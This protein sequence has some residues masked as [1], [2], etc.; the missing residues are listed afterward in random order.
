MKIIY[1]LPFVFLLGCVAAKAQKGYFVKASII[2][3]D[4]DTLQGYIDR[5]RDSRLSEGITFKQETGSNTEQKFKPGDLLGFILKDEHITC[6]TI[7]YQHIIAGENISE[8]RFAILLLKGYCSLYYLALKEDE[9]KI[10]F[11]Q[12]NDHIFLAKK[13]DAFTVLRQSEIMDDNTYSL[14]KDYTGELEKLFSDC[15]SINENMIMKTEFSKKSMLKIFEKYNLCI[16]PGVPVQSYVNTGKVKIKLGI[17]ASYTFFSYRNA[18]NSSGISGGF[19]ITVTNPD[20][21]ER[22]SFSAGFNITKLKYDLFYP[23]TLE[24]E[25]D[26]ISMY[27]FPVKGT[28]YLTRRKIAPFVS[29]GIIPAFVKLNYTGSTGYEHTDSYFTAFSS[30]GPG[31]SF[32]K[33]FVAFMAEQKGLTFGGGTYYNFQLGYIF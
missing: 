15:S 11:E 7:T 25:N 19:F 4:G 12:S 8:K 10:I 1:L 23:A 9:I 31:I 21:N 14:H 30:I 24:N 28:Y 18:S 29:F 3:K 5:V 27:R 2:K 26:K 16:Q 32:G 17:N 33:L 20:A 13:G 22:L 6:E